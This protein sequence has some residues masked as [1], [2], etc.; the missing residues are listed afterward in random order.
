MK[1]KKRIIPCMDVSNGKVVKGVRFCGIKDVGDPIEMAK[2]YDLSGADEIAL[3]DISRTLENKNITLNIIKKIT[4]AISTPLIV[5]GGINDTEDIREILKAGADKVSINS[6]ALKRPQLIKEAT[7]QFKSERIIIAID[8]SLRADLSGWDVYI[9]GG[10]INSKRDVVKWALEVTA[11]GAGEI[12]LTSMD[13][14]GTKEGYD[15]E[16]IKMV[17][18]RTGIPVIASGGAGKKEH[19]FEALTK[20]KASA[21]LAASLFHFGEIEIKTLKKYLKDKGLNIDKGLNTGY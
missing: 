20:G 17:S 21:V 9:R 7:E 16:L 19:F 13:K 1:E 3:L 2:I 15:I 5:G 12:L 6:A 14:D 8:A 10:K 18:E 4:S 11:L